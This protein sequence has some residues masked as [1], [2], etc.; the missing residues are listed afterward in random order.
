MKRIGQ[1]TRKGRLQLD[2]YHGQEYIFEIVSH[3]KKKKKDSRLEQ[4]QEFCDINQFFN[5]CSTVSIKGN[6]VNDIIYMFEII[7]K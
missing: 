2:L 3:A 6:G 7:N 5:S 1:E 4:Q